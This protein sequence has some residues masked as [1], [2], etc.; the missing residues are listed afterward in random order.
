[1]LTETD[2]Q[3]LQ[4]NAALLKANQME[5][6]FNNCA[7]ADR[8]KF[9]EFF[10]ENDVDVFSHMTEVP[11]FLF[12]GSK[13]SYDVVI[14]EGVTE[15]GLYAFADTS[16]INHVSLPEGLTTIGNGAFLASGI[17][18]II[19]P[20]GVTELKAETFAQCENLKYVKLPSSLKR[21]NPEAFFASS[22]IETVELSHNMDLTYF[23]N[24]LL[25]ST[26]WDP[27]TIEIGWSKE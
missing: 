9:V 12:M 10:L 1:M 2:I 6:F 7:R 15:I 19:I 21:I 20:E 16:N 18:E 11:S 25:P 23:L 17:R 26:K 13:I 5:K 22:N 8:V 27:N 24:K 4:S 14:P 3:F